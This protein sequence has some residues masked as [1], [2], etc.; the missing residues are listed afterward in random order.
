MVFLGARTGLRWLVPMSGMLVLSGAV[1]TASIPDA[2]GVIHGCYG[3]VTG[4]VRVIDTQAN[5]SQTCIFSETPISWNNAGSGGPR[6]VRR[7]RPWP[8]PARRESLDRKASGIARFCPEGSPEQPWSLIRP[9][10]GR[11]Q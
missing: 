9:R 11:T 6:S 1:N 4:L 3:R 8:R 7:V 5:P 2:S 10:A